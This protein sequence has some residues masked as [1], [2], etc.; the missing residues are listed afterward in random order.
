MCY[1]ASE[2]VRK[3]VLTLPL[4]L[5]NTEDADMKD[6]CLPNLTKL[7]G[8]HGKLVD[9]AGVLSRLGHHKG[10]AKMPCRNL[11]DKPPFVQCYNCSVFIAQGFVL[12]LFHTV[13]G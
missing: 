12:Y 7:K 6:I 1:E 3:Q 9:I 11:I 2:L 10:G 8:R 5:R 13:D 4:Y